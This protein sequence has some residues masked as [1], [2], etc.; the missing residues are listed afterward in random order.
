MPKILIVAPNWVGD[1][2]L[3]QPLFMRL[4]Q[5]LPGAV[6]HA[7]APPWTAPVL[8]RMP[9]IAEVIEAPFEHGRLQLAER[10]R[11]GRRLRARRYQEAIVLP[12]SFKSALVPFFADIPL[13]VGY[14]GE[15]RYGLLNLVHKPDP[16]R[17]ALMVNRYAQL[18]ERPGEP[19]PEQPARGSLVVD[20]AN[21]IITLSRLGLERRRSNVVF[22]P[23]AEFG[24]AKRWPARHFAELARRLALQGHVV[25]L[26]G[27][28]N[29]RPIGEEIARLSDGNAINLCGRTDLAGAIDLLSVSQLV[30][31]NDSGLMHVA[32]ALDKPVIALYGSSSPDHT[33]PLSERAH[34]VKLQGVECSPC[35]R[36][37][38]P[39]GHFRCMNELS[40][41]SVLAEIRPI[42]GE[43]NHARM[44]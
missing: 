14:A 12:N 36:R 33:P 4:R 40:P 7:L 26:I 5:R 29:D 35:Y 20:P 38:C 21:L 15:S 13:R 44:R 3:A 8:A 41:E 30:V 31:S 28:P 2:L 27:S 11:M 39:L 24:P 22:C 17:H 25:W 23:G 19:L 6:L 43:P 34:I 9:E 37:E 42:L 32:A 1:T 10:W 16:A 18:A